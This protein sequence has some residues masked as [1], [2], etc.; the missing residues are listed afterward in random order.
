MSG[1][2]R[3]V[4][5]PCLIIVRHNGVDL[6]ALSRTNPGPAEKNVKSVKPYRALPVEGDETF[7]R[8]IALTP[9]G[10]YKEVLEDVTASVQ[11][12]VKRLAK[13]VAKKAPAKKAA[14]KKTAK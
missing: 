4:K 11:A 12:Y 5:A 13:P 2:T 10:D 1:I 7:R 3:F 8:Q 9:I 14:A 6:V